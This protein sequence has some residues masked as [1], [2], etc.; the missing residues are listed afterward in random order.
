MADLKLNVTTHDLEFTNGNL[1]FETGIDE[2]RQLMLERYLAFKGEWYLNVTKGVPYF[3]DVFKKL[4]NTNILVS[5]FKSV[6][7]Q[8]PGVI[9][10]LSFKLDFDNTVRQLSINLRART[11]DGILTFSELI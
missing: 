10:L 5:I 1:T 9:E 11:Q 7:R 3:Q 2:I 4:V 8:T 6:A